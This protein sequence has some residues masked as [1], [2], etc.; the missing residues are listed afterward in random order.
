MHSGARGQL[1]LL[2]PELLVE[3][4][5]PVARHEADYT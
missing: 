4:S 3:P 5:R 2:E 1:A